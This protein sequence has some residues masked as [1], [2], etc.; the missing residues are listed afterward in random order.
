MTSGATSQ[1]AAPLIS[2]CVPTCN[3]PDLLAQA[4]GSCLAQ[5]YR[6]LEILIGDDSTDDATRVMVEGLAPCDAVV[7]RYEQNRPRLGQS[8]NVNRLFDR[9]RGDKLLLLHD[10]DLLAPNGLDLLAE[11]LGRFPTARC[12][13]G[14]Q[15]VI[16]PDG[17]GLPLQTD[18]WNRRYFRVDEH[19]GPQASPLL[20][21]LWQ[22]VPNDGFLIDSA[23]ARAV[24]YR[25]ESVIGHCV[26]A[27]FII[28][29]ALVAGACDFVFVPRL[30]CDYRLTPGSIAR[31]DT[32]NR[33]QDL[34][35][36]LV[37]DLATTADEEAGRTIILE[38]IAVGAALDAAMARQRWIAL[39][40]LFSRYY[41]L[42]LFSRWTLYRL[43]C[44]ASPRAGRR[45]RRLLKRDPAYVSAD[46]HKPTF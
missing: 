36:H 26:D 3:R 15:G 13:Y 14:K 44:I 18:A 11:S 20:A 32:L 22:Q 1:A 2:I 43:L 41:V 9:A 40:I 30:V 5:A 31:S 28:R 29:A 4:L 23:L 42:P 12:I 10:D 27:D 33:R 38:R 37:K 39:S 34:L 19:A 16:A 24:R 46:H 45:V 17:T 35:F 8:G 21:G 6:P 25:P 7:V